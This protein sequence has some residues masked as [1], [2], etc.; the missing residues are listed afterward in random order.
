MFKNK[1]ILFIILTIVIFFTIVRLI[2][3]FDKKEEN[4]FDIEALR[5]QTIKFYSDKDL[6]I[7]DFID[8]S[9][10][11][12]LTDSNDDDKLFISNLS[13]EELTKEDMFILSVINTNDPDYYYDTFESYIES[14]KN[15]EN[16]EKIL[17]LFNNSILKKSNNYV[18]FIISDNSK[19]VE[20][21]ILT[22]YK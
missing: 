6:K 14:I 19:E 22:Q 3:I 11:F 10:L 15:Y 13:S 1:K 16:N 9:A 18:Y 4:K 7:L 17:D 8:I 12:G 20:R 5:T 2:F 21:D